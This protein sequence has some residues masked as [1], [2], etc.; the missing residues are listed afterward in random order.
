MTAYIIADIE[1]LDQDRYQDYVRQ[2][3]AFIDRHGGK[4]IVR[5]G[6][7]ESLEGEWQPHRLIVIEFPSVEQAKAFIADPGY[8][9]VAEIRW[10]TAKT[11]LV[12]AEG[13]SP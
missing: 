3:P 9:A 7:A 11:N 6:N 1:V 12:V 5:G 4:Y 13:Y 8:Q 2:A 10:S